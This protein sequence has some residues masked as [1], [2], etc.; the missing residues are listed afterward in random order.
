[1]LTLGLP[2]G[3][4]AGGETQILQTGDGEFNQMLTFEAS[5]S[6][7]KGNS[8]VS[9][10]LAFNNRSN[11]FSDEFRYGLEIGHKFSNRLTV[12]AKLLS[13]NSL[14]NGS[15]SGVP[16]NGIFSNNIEYISFSPEVAYE[17][18]DKFGVSASVGTILDGQ[19]VLATPSYSA[20]IFM[21]L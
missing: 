18:N 11:N 6:F 5:R 4:Q 19:R 12:N 13:V 9:A 1:M 15:D 3:N 2:L 20:G 14:N 21:N 8:W 16:S 7:S 17:F 10:L